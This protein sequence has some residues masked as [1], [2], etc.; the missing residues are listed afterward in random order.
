MQKAIIESFVHLSE[1]IKNDS[2]ELKQLIER[3]KNQNSWFTETEIK[4]ALQEWARNLSEINLNNWLNK[5]QVPV[6]SPKKT[7][8]ILAG[9]IPMVGFHDVLSVLLSGH[10]ACIKLSS[11]DAVLIPYL[12]KKVSDETPI[13]NERISYPEKLN[14]I[15]AVIATGSNNSANHFEHYF[16]HIPRLIRRNRTSVAILNGLESPEDIQQLGLDIFSYYGQGCRN[17][18]KIYIPK[19]YDITYLLDHLQSFQYVIDH[20]KYYNNYNYYKSIYLV[21]REEHFDTGFLILKESTQMQAA[22][23]VLY[24]ERYNDI[25]TLTKHLNDHKEEIQC[26]VNKERIGSEIPQFNF[27]ETQCPSL[28]DYAD[29]VDTLAFLQNL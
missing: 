18:S 19:D 27:G 24:F 13:L 7:G 3:A 16:K 20:H 17:V 12:L 14:H 10:H 23:S 26:I 5:Y 8:L 1:F 11:Q 28:S 15:D 9:N 4:R 2:D 21:N 29:G 22:L 25:T 6:S